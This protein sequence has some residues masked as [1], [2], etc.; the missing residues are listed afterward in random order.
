MPYSQVSLDILILKIEMAMRNQMSRMKHAGTATKG[1]LHLV[2]V[3]KHRILNAMSL[4]ILQT[5]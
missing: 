5:T 3:L 2:E 1:I 4:K